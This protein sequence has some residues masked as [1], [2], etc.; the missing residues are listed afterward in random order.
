[1]LKEIDGLFEQGGFR[2]T[3]QSR[4]QIEAAFRFERDFRAKLD[5]LFVLGQRARPPGFAGS[6]RR[7]RLVQILSATDP[8]A[9]RLRLFRIRID[10]RAAFRDPII[11]L[12]HIFLM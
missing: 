11:D 3:R 4:H 10:G 1:M 7:R 6:S 2:A 8:D 5:A 12:S 9:K